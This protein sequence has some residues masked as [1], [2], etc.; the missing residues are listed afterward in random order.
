[1]DKAVIL[2]PEFV[3]FPEAV[4]V[5]HVFRFFLFPLATTALSFS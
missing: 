2:R 4:V 3:A 1:M 5:E